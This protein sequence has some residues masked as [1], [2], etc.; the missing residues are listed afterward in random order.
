[1]ARWLRHA[2]RRRCEK[3][4]RSAARG[5]SVLFRPPRFEHGRLFRSFPHPLF[6]IDYWHAA[7]SAAW[8]RG[9]GYF[10][11]AVLL[12]GALWTSGRAD[13]TQVLASFAAAVV[14][15]WFSF[16]VGFAAFSR[17][18]QANGLGSLLTLGLPLLTFAALRSGCPELA[19]L[20]PPGAVYLPL[21]S[22]PDWSWLP[23]PALTALFTLGLARR[24][25]PRCHID[26]RAWYDRNQGKKTAE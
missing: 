19:A 18:A 13:A 25:L 1:M 14:L 26:L 2:L 12:W 20:L 15:W 7:R 11:I 3:T 16:A 9:R 24:S 17:G 21:V 4:A 22:A 10:A 23:G 8:R 6:R 5:N